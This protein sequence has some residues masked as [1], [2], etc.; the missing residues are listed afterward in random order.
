MGH[1]QRTCLIGMR[2]GAQVGLDV[3]NVSSLYHALLMKDAGCSSNAA[4][5]VEIFGSD[6]V[7]AKN[8]S[9]ITDWSNLLEAANYAAAHTL[10]KGSLVARAQRL[11]HIATHQ[12]ETS[13]A[14]M[15]TRCT[16]GAQIALQ[17]GLGED[18]A[19][20]VLHLDEHWNGRGSPG[21][22]RGDGISLLGRIAGLAQTLEVFAKTFDVATAYDIIRRRAGKWFDPELVRAACAFE[23]DTAFWGDV[24]GRTREA[25]LGL[26][27][28]AAVEVASDERIDAI[29]DAFAQVVDAKSPFTAQHSSRV[30]D[31]AVEIAIAFGFEGTRLQTLRRAALLHDVGK[32]GVSNLILDKSGKPTD[33]EW[34][35]IRMH[36][37][38]SHQIL[39]QINGFGRL[40][41]IAA[42]HHERLD[43]RGYFRG[44]GAS[45]LDL[46]MR[47]LAVA[48]VF[49]ALSAARPY[50]GALPRD[51]VFAMLDKDAGIALDADCIAA[52]KQKHSIDTLASISE[53]SSL[54][55]SLAA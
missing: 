1:A 16:R 34:R 10:P 53:T 46:D 15:Q 3:D 13:D 4:R 31:Y 32:L 5:M 27:V 55:G 37:Y 43:G 41:E 17:I 8:M 25:L 23:H 9:K 29:C 11:L 18:A 54:Q 28:R 22:L 52:L 47:I 49:D 2:L 12:S 36:P 48:D 30:K 33:E 7:T 51:E 42:A 35:I 19:L 44:L 45:E 20:C 14:L 39:Q 26:D 38:Y 24:Q 6:D 40:A 21:H 50:R